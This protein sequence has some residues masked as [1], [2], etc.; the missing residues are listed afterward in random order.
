MNRR[1]FIE[2]LMISAL[3][4]K[5]SLSCRKLIAK[6]KL[7]LSSI[8]EIV[9][10]NAISSNNVLNKLELLFKREKN[11][12]FVL[13]PEYSFY[14]INRPVKLEKRFGQYALTGSHDFVKRIIERAGNLASKYNSNIFLGTFAETDERGNLR[15][16]LLQIDS[17]GKIVGR[18]RKFQIL[19]DNFGFK[20][21]DGKF[22]SVLPLI[23]GDLFD[24]K[25]LEDIKKYGKK[26]DIMAYTA[27]LGTNFDILSGCVQDSG[28]NIEKGFV[29]E[30]EENFRNFFYRYF[31]NISEDGIIVISDG[32]KRNSSAILRG[33]LKLFSD[34]IIKDEYVLARK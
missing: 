27:N 31:E 14:D 33:N 28:R 10:L 3:V 23:C 6:Q 22:Y 25:I 13:T 9:D 26:F 1:E 21:K 2:L 4:P 19:E 29:K 8:N 11:V 20:A 12:D 5:Y 15:N 18:K 34:Y 7:S 24:E 32:A 16:T 17:N 30:V